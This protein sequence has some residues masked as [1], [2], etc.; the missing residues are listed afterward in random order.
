MIA[1]VTLQGFTESA[2]SRTG[3]EDL[4]FQV[5]RKFASPNVTTYH[6]LMWTA[7]VKAIA[8][9]L[10]RQGVTRT[11]IVSYSHGQAAATDF[12]D[13][14]YNLGIRVD[15][16]L[17]CDPVYRPSWLPRSNWLQPFAFRALMKNSIITVPE[18]IRR[19]VGVRQK[20]T[21]PAG[22]DLRAKSSGTNIVPLRYLNYSH[23]SIDQ[24]PEWFDLVKQ[25]LEN[26][27]K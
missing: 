1:I 4:F 2:E 7:D 10:A 17:A 6:P 13:E 8:R 27:I 24:A 3:T 5:I 9:Q 18:N 23:T 22:H 14:C 15:L 16:W 11:A 26:W 12:A 25:E 20:T 19:V 21:I